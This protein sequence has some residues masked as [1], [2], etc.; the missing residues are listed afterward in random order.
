MTWWTGEFSNRQII[1]IKTVVWSSVMKTLTRAVWMTSVFW[2]SS[3][4]KSRFMRET[5]RNCS[6]WTFSGGFRTWVKMSTV[7]TFGKHS[8][9]VEFR[10]EVFTCPGAVPPSAS[11]HRMTVVWIWFNS[12]VCAGSFRRLWWNLMT[13]VLR[14]S[15]S[16]SF[17]LRFSSGGTLTYNRIKWWVL[18]CVI[19]RSCKSCKAGFLFP[20]R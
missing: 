1:I 11:W 18:L 17:I 3:Q 8:D 9:S 6:R 2:P 14:Q 20:N 4:N 12:V 10:Q 19:S 15:R 7:K 16:T 5:E 13:A